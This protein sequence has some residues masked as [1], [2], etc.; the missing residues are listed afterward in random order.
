M[1][2]E[3]ARDWHFS[4]GGVSE[5]AGPDAGL[6]AHCLFCQVGVTASRF[7]LWPSFRNRRAR[8]GGRGLTS[9]P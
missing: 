3:W 7:V 5:T 4:D 9:K 6:P 2:E 1:P 8:S